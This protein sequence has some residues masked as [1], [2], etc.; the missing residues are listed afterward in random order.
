MRTTEEIAFRLSSFSPRISIKTA[1]LC[2]YEFVLI[3]SSGK[4][5]AVEYKKNR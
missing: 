2:G 3:G 4:N 5:F 1:S